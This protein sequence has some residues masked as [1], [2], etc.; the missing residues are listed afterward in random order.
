MPKEAI[1]RKHFKEL[2]DRKEI[3][4]WIAPRVRYL[5]EC[6]IFGVFDALIV[7]NNQIVPIQYTTLHNIRARERKVKSFLERAR[8]SIYGEVWG[9][10]DK[11][12]AF[13]IIPVYSDN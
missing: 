6:D 8:V 12:K 5:K 7:R 1:I 13:L 3:P 2:C 10:D 9:W 11:D 4:F